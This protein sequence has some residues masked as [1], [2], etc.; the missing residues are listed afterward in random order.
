M[1]MATKKERVEALKQDILKN[2][3]KV[4]YPDGLTTNSPQFKKDAQR[5]PELAEKKKKMAPKVFIGD[6]N[7]KGLDWSKWGGR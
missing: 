2:P 1:A 3:N 7:T 4:E 5:F 6:V